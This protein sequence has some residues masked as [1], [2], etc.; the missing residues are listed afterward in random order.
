MIWT[1]PEDI[2]NPAGTPCPASVA[3][4]GK[5]LTILGNGVLTI[6]PGSDLGDFPDFSREINGPV[7][8]Q[9][10]DGQH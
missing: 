3:G 2:D 5:F 7:L 9:A 4:E 1:K 10:F 8:G 6:V